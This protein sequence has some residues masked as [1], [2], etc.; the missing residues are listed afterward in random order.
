[1]SSITALVH[2]AA[3]IERAQALKANHLL[4]AVAGLSR[5]GGMGWDE[6]L[7]C[8]ED[9]QNQGVQV[10]LLWDRLVEEDEFEQQFKRVT[11]AFQRSENIAFRVSD[12]GLARRCQLEAIPYE[13]SLESGHANSLAIRAWLRQLPDVRK[14]AL[15]HQIPRRN[16]LPMLK[17]LREAFQTSFEIMALGPIAMYYTP[18]KLLQFQGEAESARIQSDEMGPGRYDLVESEAGTVMFYDKWLNLL[19]HRAELTEAGMSFFRLDL[20]QVSA[21]EVEALRQTLLG[22]EV[23]LRK[24]W[25]RPLLH[26]FYGEN[27]SDSIFSKLVGRRPDMELSL[28]AEVVSRHESRLLLRLSEPVIA[29]LRVKAKD[30]KGRWHHWQLDLLETPL[31]ERLDECS[32]GDLVSVKRIRNFAVGTYLYVSTSE[33]KEG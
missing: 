33:E 5:E 23:D 22:E 3:S 4:L 18:R 14:V 16:M 21:S 10:T 24:V 2:D 28:V 30:G 20:R 12:V 26:G 1:L 29:G 32:S 6:A 11:S 17:E 31:G 15:S 7:A 27:K 13:L 9:L 19:P 8:V 25:S